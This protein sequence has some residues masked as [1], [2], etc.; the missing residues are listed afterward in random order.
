[1]TQLECVEPAYSQGAAQYIQVGGKGTDAII[2]F[3]HVDSCM[4]IVFFLASGAI[5]GGHVPVVWGQGSKDT[6]GVQDDNPDYDG[7]M[8]RVVSLMRAMADSL[9]SPLQKLITLGDGN[10]HPAIDQLLRTTFVKDYLQYE[11]KL[12][13]GVDLFATPHSVMPR[14][15]VGQVVMI[16]HVRYYSQITGR[17]KK[18]KLK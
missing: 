10:W 14:K 16:E 13:G 1:M 15:T 12:G 4:A 9:G 6:E 11:K 2:K 7:N 17:L 8:W 18:I 5:V 3:P